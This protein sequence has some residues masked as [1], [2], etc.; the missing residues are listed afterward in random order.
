MECI[1]CNGPVLW[2]GPLTAQPYTQCNNC[3]ETNCAKPEL[4]EYEEEEQI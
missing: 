2:K 4:T 3:G 1:Y